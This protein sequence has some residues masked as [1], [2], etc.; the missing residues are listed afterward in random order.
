MQN[1]LVCEF[2]MNGRPFFWCWSFTLAWRT[3][4]ILHLVFSASA[5]CAQDAEPETPPASLTGGWSG[6]MKLEDHGVTPFATLTGEAWGNVSGG[7]QQRGWANSLLDFGVELDTGKLGWWQGG[8]FLVQAH[9]VENLRN[10][11]CFSDYT[12]GFNPVSNIEAGDHLRVFNLFYRHSWRDDAV[13]L[14]VGQIAV[15]DDFMGSD[16]AGLFLNSA[17]GAMPS[18]VGTPLATSCG[19]HPPFPIYSVAAPGLFLRVQ[20]FES[21]YSQVGLYYGQP[22]FDERSNYGFDW[23]SESGFEL[24]LFWE[25]GYTYKVADRSATLRLGLSHHTGPVDDFSKPPGE[26]TDTPQT[27]P[28]FYA[29]HDLQLLTDGEGKTVLGLFARGGIT[30]D[31][32]LS[33][34]AWYADAG[35]NW[36][37]PLPGRPD[38]V[39]GVGVSFT[40]FG[41]AFRQ[42]T[43]PNGVAADETTVELTYKAQL[44]RWLAM[45]A[46]VQFLFNPAVNPSSNS[47]ETATVLGLRAEITF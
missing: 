22:G 24:G 19:G 6:R 30:P 5:L 14:K 42:S 45:Q 34:I 32:D 1:P 18:Q 47:R 20:P 15:D 23:A 39:A 28:N 2:A 4:I 12:G 3:G 38:D 36:F 40:R 26:S 25:S 16:Y 21:F 43:G 9:W 37:A 7:L 46:D 11:V 35:L 41:E 8:T 31:P 44:T 17:F 13:V 10:D 27:V 29:I 33:M